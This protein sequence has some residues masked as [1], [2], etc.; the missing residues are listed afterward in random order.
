MSC[1]CLWRFTADN[2]QGIQN[3]PSWQCPCCRP[4]P[5]LALQYPP[6]ARHRDSIQLGGPDAGQHRPPW[7]AHAGSTGGIDSVKRRSSRSGASAPREV[8]TPTNGF[9]HVATDDF[10]GQKV[11]RVKI[12]IG[13][14]RGSRTVSYFLACK[15]GQVYPKGIVLCCVNLSR[16]AGILST[17]YLCF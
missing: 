9:N 5:A 17:C 4:P 7:G 2:L 12:V 6:R 1:R 8:L 10:Y 3:S 16:M 14:L 13:S 11:G 15:L